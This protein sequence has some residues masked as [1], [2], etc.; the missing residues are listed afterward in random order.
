MAL[1]SRFKGQTLGLL[2]VVLLAAMIA[3]SLLGPLLVPY[4]PNQIDMMAAFGPPS[5][6]HPLGTDEL[7]RDVLVRLM[8]GGRITLLVG[9]V[10]MLVAVVI[11]VAVGLLGGFFGGWLDYLL[12]RLTDMFMSVPAFFVMLTILTFFGPSLLTIVIAIGSTSWMNVAR[13]VRSEVLR[14]KAM[15][16]V[17]GARALGAGALRLVLRHAL[18]NVMPTVMVAATLGVAWAILVAT[19]LSYL[20]IGIQPP[21]PSWGNMLTDSQNYFWISPLLVVYPG[22]LVVLTILAVNFLGETLG[23]ILAPRRR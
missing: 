11:G 12:M 22:L 18:P 10:A 23:S 15:E 20:G 2:S 1:L 19:S 5:A 21:T 9:V 13:V 4:S 7:G 17:E 14:I 8:Y 16:Y 3:F 6:A